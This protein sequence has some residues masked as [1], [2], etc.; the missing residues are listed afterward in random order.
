MINRQNWIV[1]YLESIIIALVLALIIRTFLFQPFFIPSGSMEPTLQVGDR[2]IV[3]KFTYY[4]NELKLGDVVVFKY[5]LDPKRDFIKRVIGVPGDVIEAR[6]S[7]LLVNGL[8]VPEPYVPRDYGDFG[9]V[10]VP[11]QHFFVLGDNR[12]NSQDS[13]NWGFVPEENL[14]GKAQVIFWPIS[15]LSVIR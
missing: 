2:I 6:D 11:E 8:I 10:E 5:P 3:S 9:P 15:R 14:V 4:F 1:E 7:Q 12:T 13:R